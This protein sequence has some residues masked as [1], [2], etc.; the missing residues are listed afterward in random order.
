LNN[1]LRFDPTAP[2]VIHNDLLDTGILIILRTNPLQQK[3]IFPYP[4]PMLIHLQIRPSSV[5]RYHLDKDLRRAQILNIA[6]IGPA[7]AEKSR[8]LID[9]RFGACEKLVDACVALETAESG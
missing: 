7:K 9:G 3:L 5:P 2:I 4:T 6:Q 1:R 8:G